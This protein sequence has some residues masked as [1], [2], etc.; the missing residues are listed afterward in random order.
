MHLH[1]IIHEIFEGP[2]AFLAWAEMNGHVVSYSRVYEQEPLP[3]N[4]EDI[5]LL[6]VLGG[7]QSPS[8]T[9]EMCPHFDAVAEIS[10][11]KKCIEANKAVIGVCLGAQLIGE[12]LGASHEHSPEKEVGAFPITLTEEGKTNELFSHFA[13]TSTVGHWHNDMPGLT[14]NSKILAFSEGCPQQIVE[15]SELVYG[16][17]CHMEFT[18]ELIELLIQHSEQE[19]EKYKENR[20]VQ[21]PEQLKNNNYT[22]MNNQ[23]YTFLDK[24]TS[25]YQLK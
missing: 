12:A 25:L 5:D 20:F 24:L 17:Q 15:Y 23:L 16:F 7:P 4:I 8:T 21:S 11:I 6:I 18:P 10:V 13:T 9:K 22:P 1:F 2:G 3:Y 19:L 14:K